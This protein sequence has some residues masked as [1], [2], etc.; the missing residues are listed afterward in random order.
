M[1]RECLSIKIKIMSSLVVLEWLV[2]CQTACI[3]VL[4]HV[5]VRFCWRLQVAARA[6]SPDNPRAGLERQT[7]KV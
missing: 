2:T 1:G 7:V 3:N 5:T 6:R 4:Y